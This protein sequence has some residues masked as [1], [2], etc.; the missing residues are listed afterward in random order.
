[1]PVLRFDDEKA[2]RNNTNAIAA[3]ANSTTL[4]GHQI[5]ATNEAT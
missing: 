3:A 4:W 2:T 5:L 1:M